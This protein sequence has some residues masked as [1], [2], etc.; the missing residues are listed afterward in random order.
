[1]ITAMRTTSLNE[2]VYDENRIRNRNETR[3][4]GAGATH[5]RALASE[6]GI[7]AD[8]RHEYRGRSRTCT[9]ALSARLAR[10]NE[11]KR[12]KRLVRAGRVS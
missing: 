3:G 12:L 10:K 5:E 8:R 1:M 7:V 6:G 2:F 11:L 9:D 4:A